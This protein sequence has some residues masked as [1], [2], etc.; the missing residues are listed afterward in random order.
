MQSRFLRGNL[1]APIMENA[2]QRDGFERCAS[3]SMA[4]T[5]INDAS[6]IFGVCCTY[7][8]PSEDLG[9]YVVV[10]SRGCFTTSLKASGADQ[11]VLHNHE[12]RLVLGRVSAGTARFTESSSRVSFEAD[13]P[14]A[15]W[16]D[17]LMES[18]RR[19]DITAA[20]IGY[21]TTL[22]HWETRNGTRTRVIDMAE[23]VEASIAARLEA[24]RVGT[25]VM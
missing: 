13:P 4:A 25:R 1:G 14:A 12:S 3:R 7:G 21:I 11:R 18:M 19:G 22:S 15:Y 20:D 5:P 6:R 17:D 8:E 16:A 23:L 10:F 24:M 9:D 2:F